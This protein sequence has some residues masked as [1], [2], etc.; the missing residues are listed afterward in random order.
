MPANPT[1]PQRA[2]HLLIVEDDL[3]LRELLQKHLENHGYITRGVSDAHT[4]KR[5]LQRDHYDLMI[6]DIG[7]PCTDGLTPCSRF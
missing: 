3:K 2:R 4:M 7:L 6:L 1:L 5:A